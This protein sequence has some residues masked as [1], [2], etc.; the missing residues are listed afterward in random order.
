MNIDELLVKSRE[1]WGKKK[2]NLS[3]ILVRLGVVYG[4]I[5]RF[6]RNDKK[7]L[8]NHN[9]EE[10]KKELGSVIF[11]TIRWCD[12]LG[13]DPKECVERAIEAQEEFAKDNRGK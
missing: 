4:D 5:C 9:D 1:I 10:L 8:E 3:Q 13:Y 11:S 6:E 7:D 2:Q 12:D